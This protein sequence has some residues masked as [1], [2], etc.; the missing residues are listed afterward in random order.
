M[1]DNICLRIADVPTTT[2]SEAWTK[3]APA[4]GAHTRQKLSSNTSNSQTC[5]EWSATDTRSKDESDQCDGSSQ[6]HVLAARARAAS[7][8]KVFLLKLLC[9]VL[10]CTHAAAVAHKHLVRSCGVTSGDSQAHWPQ[11]KQNDRKVEKKDNWSYHRGS[12]AR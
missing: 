6:L 9:C 7:G 11:A 2:N 1:F 12:W 5:R 4:L 10:A 3:L 8:R